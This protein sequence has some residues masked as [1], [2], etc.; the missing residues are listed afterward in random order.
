MQQ[1][2]QSTEAVAAVLAALSGEAPLGRD[3]LSPVPV[4]SIADS[5]D[6]LPPQARVT[7]DAD[8]ARR[9]IEAQRLGAA[10][11][12][13][14]VADGPVSFVEA[15]TAG[16]GR[17][18][19]LVLTATADAHGRIA[20][21]VVLT[22]AAV[23][24][25]SA[26]PAEPASGWAVAGPRLDRY[27]HDLEA[28]AFAAAAEA[29]SVDCLYSHPPYGPGQSRIDFAGRAALLDGWLTKRGRTSSRHGVLRIVQTGRHGF[30]EGFA[31][32]DHLTAGS[33]FLS[34]FTLAAD[35]LIERYVAYYA[36]PQI[37]A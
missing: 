18:R 22:G 30:I 34:S 32:A 3:V 28:G 10:T 33:T 12:V 5:D 2:E 37:P 35:G 9:A 23:A 13:I 19:S 27:F 7:H 6:G 29:F 24:G 16:G 21:L 17:P 15:R 11:T 14:A 25:P 4:V 36:A 20:R 1:Q 8:E 31:G 26:A